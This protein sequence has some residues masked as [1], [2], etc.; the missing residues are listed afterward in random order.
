MQEHEQQK[1]QGRE[2][3][4]EV[5]AR[6][7]RETFLENESLLE[8]VFGPSTLLVRAGSP[9]EL[10]TIAR[11]LNGNLT[12][13]VHGSE[14]DLAAHTGLVRV[15]KRRVGHLIFNGFPTGVRVCHAMHHGG[16][17]PATTDVRT[18]SIGT[19]AIKRFAR[20]VAYQNFPDS[21]RPPELKDRNERD[22]WRLVDGE[23]TKDDV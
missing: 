20:P 11:Q 1:A 2:T 3:W 23:W 15:L 22:I 6:T 10:T 18:T 5:L 4:K 16:P 17:Y 12:A 9:E 14:E 13:S 8:E 7:L 19:A 21:A